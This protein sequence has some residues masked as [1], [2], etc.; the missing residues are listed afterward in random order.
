MIGILLFENRNGAFT[1]S[2]VNT[3][4]C[5]I[6]EDVVAISDNRKFLNHFPA[7]CVDD[8]E[9]RWNAR[10]DEQSVI[11]FVERHSVVT[12]RQAHT[13]ARYNGVRFAVQDGD[14]SRT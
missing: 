3:L 4:P 9:S 8:D 10:D 11:R 2:C 6:E 12:K 1:P 7:G 14:F 13:P 5:L